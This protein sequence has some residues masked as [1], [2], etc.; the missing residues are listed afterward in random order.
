[1]VPAVPATLK[2]Q[3]ALIIMCTSMASASVTK[4][5]VQ[6]AW[7]GRIRRRQTSITRTGRMPA[8]R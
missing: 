7:A 3:N 4:S 2:K 1:V 6:E 5:P 8:D